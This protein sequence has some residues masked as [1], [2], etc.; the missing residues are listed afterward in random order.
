MFVAFQAAQVHASDRGCEFAVQPK[1][2]AAV[3][4]R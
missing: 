1:E 3:R 2:L 4:Q